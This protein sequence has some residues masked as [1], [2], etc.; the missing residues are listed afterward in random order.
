MQAQGT[1]LKTEYWFRSDE[2]FDKLY[3]PSIRELA[4][5]HW[6]PLDVA[7]EAA[8]FLAAE[9]NMRILDIGSGVAK[10][11]LAGAYFHPDA[12]FYGVEQRKSLMVHSEIARLKLGLENVSLIHSNF[13]TLDFKEYDHF[14]FFNSFFENLSGAGKIDESLEYSDQLYNYYNRYLF[15][16]LDLKPA[17]T[18]LATYYSSGDE[19]PDSYH[20]VGTSMNQQ[21]KFWVKV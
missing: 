2:H 10:F 4:Y 11:C 21:L 18:R 8:A 3:A 17:G 9:K 1:E 13:T 7:K 5:R 15:R 12:H 20:I 19:I 6:T 16:Q 14:Y